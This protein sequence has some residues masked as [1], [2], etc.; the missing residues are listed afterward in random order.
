[1][2]APSTSLS[3]APE[4]QDRLG[5]ISRL[6]AVLA[7]TAFT[8]TPEKGLELL[9]KIQSLI[10]SN[11]KLLVTINRVDG[12]SL[13][14]PFNSNFLWFLRIYF[15]LGM[16]RNKRQVGQSAE[17]MDEIYSPIAVK[18]VIVRVIPPK[19]PKEKAVKEKAVKEKVAKEKAHKPKA[20]IMAPNNT[21][22][23]P[24]R[25]RPRHEEEITLTDESFSLKDFLER[26]VDEQTK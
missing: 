3:T 13:T 9:E 26:K 2:D 25:L 11:E 18:D 14:R 4:R 23:S 17:Y 8:E 22:G 1:M 21:L 7:G 20:F 5:E 12:T 15:D 6:I 24:V 16:A 10:P 19:A